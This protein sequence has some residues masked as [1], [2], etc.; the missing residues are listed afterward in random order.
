MQTLFNH[1]SQIFGITLVHSLWQ[2][3]II[4][5]VLRIALLLFKKASANGKY[6]MAML[7]LAASVV[8]PLFTLLIEIVNHPCVSAIADSKLDVLPY[9][10]LIHQSHAD[11]ASIQQWAFN[12]EHYL[13]YLV[14]FW[15]VG[16]VL[17]TTR[18]ALGWQSIYFLKQ[19]LTGEAFLQHKTDNLAAMLNIRKHI[20]VFISEHL[21]VPC[22]IGYIKPMILLPVSVASQFSIEQIESIIIHD[23]HTLNVTITWLTCCNR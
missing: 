20:G 21:D 12:M 4:Y 9:I 7:A 5:G 6:N 18:L 13:P 3:L 14:A 8:W 10:P 23:R 1:Y 11:T 22:I 16:I 15:L 19:S 17:N 2:G